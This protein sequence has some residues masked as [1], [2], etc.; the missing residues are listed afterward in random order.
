MVCRQREVERAERHVGSVKCDVLKRKET[1][2]G[3][4]V[5]PGP[6][7]LSPH[8]IGG[9]HRVLSQRPEA[10]HYTLEAKDRPSGCQVPEDLLLSQQGVVG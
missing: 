3:E 4:D 1:C 10:G 9:Y 2:G 8:L 7:P 6:V 5:E